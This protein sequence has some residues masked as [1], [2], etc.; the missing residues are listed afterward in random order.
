MVAPCDAQ[1]AVDGARDSRKGSDAKYPYSISSAALQGI[2]ILFSEDGLGNQKLISSILRKA[3]AKVILTENGTLPIEQLTHDAT[4]EVRYLDTMPL[5]LL[6]SDM[7]MPEIDGYSTAIF[8]RD[9]GSSLPMI[10]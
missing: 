8:L 10:A 5:D 1:S 3:G 6:L 2:K 9:R 4:L 7:Q